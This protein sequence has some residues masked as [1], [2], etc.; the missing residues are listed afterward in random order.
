[1]ART[2]HKDQD[3]EAGLV[4]KYTSSLCT[5]S[6]AIPRRSGVWR[7]PGAVDHELVDLVK[8]KVQDLVKKNRVD[9]V[10][11]EG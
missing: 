7:R 1:M 2:Y 4:A 5:D 9:E 8:E 6:S 10:R 3:G 11:G